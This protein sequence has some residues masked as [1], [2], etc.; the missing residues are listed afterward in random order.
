MDRVSKTI[1][2]YFFLISCEALKWNQ[3]HIVLSGETL[4]LEYYFQPCQLE[5][6]KQSN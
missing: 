1:L 5:A 4:N 6:L 2:V 3:E